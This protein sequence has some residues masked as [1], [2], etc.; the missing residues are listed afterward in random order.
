MCLQLFS[1]CDIYSIIYKQAEENYRIAL[2]KNKENK[3]NINFN[4]GNSIYKQNNFETASSIYDIAASKEENKKMQSFI[5][6]NKGNSLLKNN[7]I[8][9]SIEYYKKTLKTSIQTVLKLL[10]NKLLCF[11]YPT[12][13]A[14]PVLGPPPRLRSVR[15]EP[16]G[17]SFMKTKI[18]PNVKKF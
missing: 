7:Q 3:E 10:D 6:Y 4:L 1:N 17:K 9:E 11:N 14:V 2:E 15:F 12:T 5:Y 13:T 16:S 8:E 18:F